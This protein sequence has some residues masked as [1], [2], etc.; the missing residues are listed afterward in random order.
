MK[1]WRQLFGNHG[2]KQTDVNSADYAMYSEQVCVGSANTQIACLLWTLTISLCHI[3][4]CLWRKTLSK[5]TVTPLCT[6]KTALGNNYWLPQKNVEQE[7]G[8]YKILDVAVAS[9]IQESFHSLETSGRGGNV[10]NCLTVL[11]IGIRLEIEIG[12][13]S[14]NWNQIKTDNLQWARKWRC[15]KTALIQVQDENK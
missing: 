11:G 9:A 15:T 3:F 2:H 7:K 8:T 10:E 4:P 5:N 14:W 12:T 1:W 6:P 13:Q